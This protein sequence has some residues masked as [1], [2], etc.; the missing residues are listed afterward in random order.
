MDKT[1]TTK[2]TKEKRKEKR[3]Q[4]NKR[5]KTKYLKT[6]QMKSG[7][8]ERGKLISFYHLKYYPDL[9]LQWFLPLPWSIGSLFSRLF[10]SLLSLEQTSL[11]AGTICSTQP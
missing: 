10:F 4:P 6:R 7:K 1:T 5:R 11:F 2:R 9:H 8:E 3:S